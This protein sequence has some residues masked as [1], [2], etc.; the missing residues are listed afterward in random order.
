MRRNLQVLAL[1]GSGH[2]VSHF[3]AL[4]LPPLFP[5]LREHLDV[6]Y[7]ALGLLVTMF[8]L[9]TGAAQIPA[10]FLVDRFGAR[11]LL[12]LG[13]T[14]MGAAMTAMGFAPSYW[15][16]LVLVAAVGI[17]NSVFHPADYA[18]L[19][20]S[21]DHSWLG[22]AFGIHT[23]AGFIG[24]MAAPGGMIALTAL[25]GWRGA[26]TVAGLLAFAVLGAM[27]ACGH[28]LR[29]EARKT[30][31][32]QRRAAAPAGARSLLFTAPVLLL[33]SFYLLNAMMTSGV[34]SF[35]VTALNSLH[36]VDLAFA[37]VILTAFLIAASAGVLLGGMVADHTDRYAL[38]TVGAFGT[39]ALMMLAVALLP[40]PA[41]VM[42]GLFVLVGLLQGSVRTSRDMLVRK[43]TP[44]GATGRVFA[45][46]MTGLNVG[47]A[48][49]PVLFG[50]LLDHG[51]PQLVF[52]LMA[53]FAVAVAG[54]VVLVQA[55]IT[56]QD[57][58]QRQPQ[59]PA[60]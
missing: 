59:V 32:A 20:A 18:V 55:A 50:V 37:N 56:A 14:I 35:S 29:D 52:L 45:F 15:L 38:V 47:G 43:I 8:N 31:A 9:A 58:R 17:G 19:S 6:S 34:Q 53:A 46:V 48:I 21:V 30:D 41:A 42:L 3:Y 54:I 27:L 36:G 39:V 49:T 1:I 10:G 40:L 4:T 33:F 57:A 11:R 22:R 26:I 25:V 44:A 13:L 51:A 60:E 24:F 5:L 2:A 16:M 23:F 28:L 12:L 7:A